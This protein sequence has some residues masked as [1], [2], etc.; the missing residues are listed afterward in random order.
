MVKLNTFGG[1]AY[2][3]ESPLVYEIV[4]Y[5]FHVLWVGKTKSQSYIRPVGG[6]QV[7]SSPS[8]LTSSYVYLYR[9]ENL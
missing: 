4:L 5:P 7:F 3:W 8:N 9:E 6:I 1:I 2:I